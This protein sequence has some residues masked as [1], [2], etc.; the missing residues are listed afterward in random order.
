MKT[1]FQRWSGAVAAKAALAAALGM[2]PGAQAVADAASD[3]P[4]VVDYRY[5]AL[6]SW[7]GALGLPDDSFKCVVDA[8]GRFMTELGKSNGRQGVYPDPPAQN[9]V[10]IHADLLGGATRVD[11]RMVS[12]RVPIAVTRKRQGEIA[13]TEYLFLA[14]PL[15]WSANVKGADLRGRGSR[16]DSRQYLLMT[17]YANQGGKPL[18]ITPLIHVTGAAPAAKLDNSRR[19][20]SVAANTR[21]WISRGI[22]AFQRDEANRATLQLEK[23]TLQPGAKTRWTLA[24][25]RN[26]FVGN[27]P[28]DWVSAEKLRSEAALYWERSAALPYDVI[29]VPDAQ[30]QALLDTSVRELYQMRYV[31]RGL[32]AYFFGPGCY[33]DYWIVDGCFATEALD[34]LGRVEDAGGYADYLLLHQQSDGRIQCMKNHWKETGV[35]LLT[36]HRH[37]QMTQDKNW[38][39]ERWPQFARAVEAIRHLRRSGSSADPQALNYR[40]SPV[41]FGD[42]GIGSAAEYTNNDWLLAGMK[43]AIE[44][45]Q[46]LGKSEDAKAWH[47]EYQD[48]EQAFRKAIERDAKTDARGNRY[49]PVLMGPVAPKDP[50]RGQWAFCQAVY[51]GR[52]FAKDDPL[53]LGTMQMLAAHEVQGG[54]VENSGWFGIWP[55]CGSFYGHDRLWLGEGAR[56][57]RLLYAFANHASPLRNWREEMPKQTRPGERFPYSKGGGDMPH[58]SAAAEFIRLTAHLLAFDRGSELHLLEGLPGEW[59]RPGA[60]T[61]LNGLETPFGPLSMQLKVAETGNRAHLSVQPLPAAGACTR[62]VVHL[63][64][65]G[66][67]ELSP[68]KSQDLDLEWKQGPARE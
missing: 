33:N 48:F 36:L 53:M 56:A 67:K 13:V 11:Q 30:I 21:C 32:P 49:I 55:Q 24:I 7:I 6:D 12:P 41:G 5:Y 61:R 59:F 18:Q 19:S 45:A 62:L 22:A 38:L 26:G 17:E 64:G 14:R 20:F 35:A 40:L 16:P 8:D 31:I 4:D 28:V 1:R 44:A 42:G 52:I 60:V 51:P 29:Q 58:V 2:A 50:A 37:A 39:V 23:I 57:S 34:M 15:D 9:A 47:E 3:A 63:P 68:V 66:T 27:G 46:W 43:T 65:G 25:E 54:I 10:V